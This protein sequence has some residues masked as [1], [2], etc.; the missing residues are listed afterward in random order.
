MIR[1]TASTLQVDESAQRW[2][3]M[4]V[5]FLRYAQWSKRFLLHGSV[6]SAAYLLLLMSGPATN[7]RAQPEEAWGTYLKPFAA[8]SMWNSRPVNP[9]L[10]DY[11]LPKTEY[12]PAVGEGAYSTGVFL[13]SGND[14]SE[15]ISDTWSPDDEARRS[16]TI[17][18]WPKGVIPA[19][20]TDG[21]ADIVD[22]ILGVI[23]SFWRLR[24]VGPAWAAEQYAWTPLAGSGWGDPAHYFQGARAAGVASAGG[25]IRRHELHDGDILYRHALAASLDNSAFRH[26]YVFPATSEDA[27]GETTYAGR[28]PMGALMMLPADFDVN[29][30]HTPH[31]KKIAE[32]LKVYGARVVDRNHQTRFTIVAE[33]G[34]GLNLHGHGWNAVAAQDLEL[35]ADNL[36]MMIGNSGYIDGN[37]QLFFPDR[38]LNRLSMRGPWELVQGDRI[39]SFDTWRQA[40][41]FPNAD[42]EIVQAHYGRKWSTLPSWARPEAGHAYRFSVTASGGAKLRLELRDGNGTVVD[43]T[44]FL[45]DGQSVSFIM[46]ESDPMPVLIARSGS[47]RGSWV[48]G[49]VVRE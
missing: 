1:L 8:N 27:N 11:V 12:Y 16:I 35:L 37:G 13:A 34:S 21:H 2:V 24:K 19:A 26:G 17:P 44:A 47:G 3:L 18:H 4:L 39:G 46:P 31:L 22:P 42:S 7:L 49:H 29:K 23:H 25:L 45:G 14:G 9:V 10:A 43:A 30:I 36:R 5:V 41:V 28:V 6:L 20:G 15:T 33:N 48:R 38:N 32:T 40:L